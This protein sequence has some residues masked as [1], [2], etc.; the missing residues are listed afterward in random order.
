MTHLEI[1]IGREIDGIIGYDLL[2]NY[3]VELNYDDNEMKLYDTKSYRYQGSGAS[4]PIKLTSFI[5][6]IPASTVFANGEQIEGEFFVDTGAKTTVDFN[7]PFV[8]ENALAGKIGDSY[9]YLVAGLGKKEYE[10]HKGA[11]NSF[12]FHGFEF[13]N[14]PVGLSHA[15]H[16][17]QNHKKV[18][19]ILG[20]ALLMR[21][22]MIYDYHG[23]RMYWEPNRKYHE[24]FAVNASGLELQLSDD[25]SEVLVHKVFDNSPASEA[26]IAVDA[27]IEKVN[28]K[29]AV[30]IGLAGLRSILSQ[31]GGE[32]KLIIDEQEIALTLRALL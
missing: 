18:S 24:G 20:G 28:G 1:S 22:N 21:F 25:K 7:T 19:G 5:P 2:K 23:K 15:K 27:K 31:S 14:L 12:S 4:F 32:V 8:E 3:I 17:I 9:I 16:G 11:V 30:D 29:S 26:G 6:H 13:R 10:H